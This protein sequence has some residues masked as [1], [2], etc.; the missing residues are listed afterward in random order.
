MA[1]RVSPFPPNSALLELPLNFLFPRLVKQTAIPT[2][3][4]F[5]KLTN[6]LPLPVLI[7]FN[8]LP[9]QNA[10]CILPF[11]IFLSSLIIPIYYEIEKKK[12]L[13]SLSLRQI[14]LKHSLEFLIS[15]LKKHNALLLFPLVVRCTLT[16][17]LIRPCAKLPSIAFGPFIE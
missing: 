5:F 3:L 11:N 16:L 2:R 7:K 15:I 9:F 17:P 13:N 8:D 6:K 14:I 10:L 12:Q 4:I 1:H